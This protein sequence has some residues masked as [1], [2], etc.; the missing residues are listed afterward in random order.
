MNGLFQPFLW[1]FAAVFFDDIL[2][3]STSLVLHLDHLKTIFATLSQSKFFLSRSKCLF[4]QE[5]IH[6]LGHIVSAQGVAL[7]PD[8]IQ[9]MLNWPL[10]TSSTT[11]HGFLGLTG[12]YRKFIRGYA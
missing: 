5:R 9:I 11:L 2:V 8:K 1:K 10:P 12:F 3:Y 4:S 6:Y 7:D